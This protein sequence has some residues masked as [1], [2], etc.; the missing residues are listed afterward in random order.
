MCVD[1]EEKEV[2]LIYKQGQV[3]K[4][5]SRL[6]IGAPLAINFRQGDQ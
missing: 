4:A 3:N 5:W 1:I 2:Y 6:D